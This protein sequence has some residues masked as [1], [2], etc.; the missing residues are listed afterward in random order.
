MDN[1]QKFDLND[2]GG[3]V[4]FNDLPDDANAIVPAGTYAAMVSDAY[5]QKTKNGNGYFI[6]AEFKIT[7]GQYRGSNVVHRFNW[8][9]DNE[10]AVKIGKSQFKGLLVALNKEGAQLNSLNVIK[11]L[12]LMID[13]DVTQ[14]SKYIDNQGVERN[15]NDQNEIKRFNKLDT[16]NVSVVSD[17]PTSIGGVGVGAQQTSQ[18]DPTPSNNTSAGAW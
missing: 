9:N 12:P 4:N 14:G 11:D 6:Y 10:I 8:V 3:A 13:V 15:G 5:L 16:A 17:N 1:V 18:V 2:V 7:Q